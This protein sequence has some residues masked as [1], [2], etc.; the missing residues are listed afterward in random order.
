MVDTK[1]KY[2]KEVTSDFVKFGDKVAVAAAVAADPDDTTVFVEELEGNLVSSE[3]ITMQ[4]KPVGKYKIEKENG[5][6]VAFLGSVILDDK[7]STVEIGTDIRIE[8]VG[9]E[10]SATAGH[11]PTKQFR[12]YIAE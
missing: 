6:I 1:S 11:S 5:E 7:L 2:T 9:S 4:G 8:L 10:K 12:V 3:S